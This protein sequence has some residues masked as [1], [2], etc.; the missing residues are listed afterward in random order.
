MIPG[1]I[2]LLW[3]ARTPCQQIK[4]YAFPLLLVSILLLLVV[5]IPGLDLGLRIAD[6]FRRFI[7]GSTGRD[8]QV[9]VFILFGR[10]VGEAADVDRSDGLMPFIIV[11]S[12]VLG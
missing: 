12:V 8:R 10:L 4:R 11:L 6:S 7:L 5:F 9:D 2:G 3:F 1:L